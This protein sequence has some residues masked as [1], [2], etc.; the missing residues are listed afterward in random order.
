MFVQTENNFNRGR[1]STV[2]KTLLKLGRYCL[3]MQLY[4]KM[5]CPA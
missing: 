1:E 2:L 5:P 3:K 4:K